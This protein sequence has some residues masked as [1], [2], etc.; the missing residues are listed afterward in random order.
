M[1][2]AFAVV[3]VVWGSTYLAIRF[4]IETLPPLLMAAA[5]FL[6]AGVILYA[7]RRARGVP[8][9]STRNWV[10]AVVVGLL[11]LLGGNG[12][13]VWAE[14]TV[15]SG[16]AA[17]LVAVVPLWMVLLDWL[18]PGGRRP[19][20]I[21]G[22]GLA[23]GF[24][25]VALLIGP[26]AILRG[27]ASG[28]DPFG[29]GVLMVGSFC[30]AAGSIYSRSAP[31]PPAPLLTTGMQMIGGGTGLLIAGLATGEASRLSLSGAS[32]RSLLSL[33]YL[34]V[35]GAIVAYSAYTWLLRVVP[36]AQV[37]TYA[38][39]NPVVAVALGWAFAGE[40]VTARTLAAAAVIVGSVALITIARPKAR[41]EPE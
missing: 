39:V 5:R 33:A 25:G 41:P 6:T 8:A 23:V 20:A 30:W 28:V 36:A 21:V 24:A 12:A 9:P 16:V 19:G 37:S 35:F 26:G 32:P 31:L 4:A 14:Q 10:A 18:S 22:L 29:A 2:L 27:A 40:P 17:L 1:L 13:V 3:Y 38:Y 15:P 7:W 34:I 11:L